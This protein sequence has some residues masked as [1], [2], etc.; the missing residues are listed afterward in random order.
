MPFR[1]SAAGVIPLLLFATAAAA[2]TLVCPAGGTPP[3]GCPVSHYHIL[4]WSSESN[5]PVELF[6]VNAFA[7]QAACEKS[8]A[9]EMAENQ[10]AIA[11][12]RQTQPKSRIQPDRFGPCHCDMTVVQANPYF[13]DDAHRM[14]QVRLRQQFLADLREDLLDAGLASD[15]SVVRALAGEASTIG[16]EIW[17]MTA[18]L[19]DTL[20]PAGA[21]PLSESALKET[22]IGSETTSTIP[23]GSDL[24]LLEIPIPTEEEVQAI[25]TARA[26][27]AAAPEESVAASSA[28]DEDADPFVEFETSRVQRIL[29]AANAM[30]EATSKAKILEAAM[31][32]LQ[33]LSNLRTL[34]DV[35]GA[36]SRLARMSGAARDETSRLQLVSALF[37]ADVASHWAVGDANDIVIE[38]PSNVADDP[39]AVLRDSTGR[40]TAEQRKAAMY[41]VLA[42]NPS[43]TASQQSWL[44]NLIDES[45]QK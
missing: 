2:Q 17:P 5:R 20:P 31:Q 1:K 36:R 15:S 23:G 16:T 35:A 44:A 25:L 43:L 34:T 33:L 21:Q 26:T 41:L 6:G 12:I 11:A 22:A 42:R 19:P 4:A 45:L 9:A 37:G 28:P 13:L 24:T 29:Q 39:I 14:A 10:A 8:R 30:T 38:W 40:Y 32:R 18:P 27:A 3:E 7:S